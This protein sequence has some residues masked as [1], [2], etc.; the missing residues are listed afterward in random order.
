MCDAAPRTDG[1]VVGIAVEY[2]ISQRRVEMS[3]VVGTAD[4][5]SRKQI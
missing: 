4:S 2:Q 3:L 1:P 5:H